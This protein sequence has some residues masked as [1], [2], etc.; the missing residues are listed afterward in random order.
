MGPPLAQGPE[1]AVPEDERVAGTQNG[2]LDLADAD[3]VVTG[4]MDF[5]QAAL[6]PGRAAL[7]ERDAIGP[8]PMRYLPPRRVDSG[9]ATSKP[10]RDELLGAGQDAHVERPTLDHR[11][12]RRRFPLEADEHHRRLLRDGNQSA[13]GK[14]AEPGPEASA[15]HYHAR[16]KPRHDVPELLRCQVNPKPKRG[17]TRTSCSRPP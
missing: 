9:R 13:R 10:L 1:R 17:P 2:R 8:E 5:Q 4:R 16:R 6:Q 15:H 3:V 12:A 11:G 14:P 7:D